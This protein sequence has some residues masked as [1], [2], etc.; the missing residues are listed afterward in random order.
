[1]AISAKTFKLLAVFFQWLV[2][3]KILLNF[4]YKRAKYLLTAVQVPFQLLKKRHCDGETSW[5]AGDSNF[6]NKSGF[7]MFWLI[8]ERYTGALDEVKSWY[9]EQIL[10][11]VSLNE[12][13]QIFF[14]NETI[15]MQV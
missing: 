2:L 14:M 7:P 1:M 4:E 5:K 6:N 3:R 10:F 9:R 11:L 15:S 8:C 13:M 12:K